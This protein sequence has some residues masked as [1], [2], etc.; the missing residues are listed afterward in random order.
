MLYHARQ[1]RRSDDFVE[2]V[3]GSNQIY[4]YPIEQPALS[5]CHYSSGG[6]SRI[7][8]GSRSPL[9]VGEEFSSVQIKGTSQGSQF[10][11]RLPT[12]TKFLNPKLMSIVLSLDAFKEARQFAEVILRVNGRH[13]SVLVE[14]LRHFRSL[15]ATM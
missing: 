2:P 8:D 7:V 11:N 3:I 4:R 14:F 6:V 1:S 12:C 5:S 15:R 13:V 10:D 9:R